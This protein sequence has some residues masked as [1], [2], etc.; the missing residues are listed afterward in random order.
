MKKNYKTQFPNSKQITNS[1]FSSQTV[2]DLFDYFYFCFEY[3][4]EFG[5]WL[6][7]FPRANHCNS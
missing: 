5:A 4:L 6:L 1:N 7:G 2:D 3:Y